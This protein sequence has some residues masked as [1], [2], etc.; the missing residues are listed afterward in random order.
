MSDNEE[1][2]KEPT[3]LESLLASVA[4][5]SRSTRI[6][7]KSSYL[8]LRKILGDDLGNLTEDQIIA[9]ILTKPNPNSQMAIINIA[10]L[11]FNILNK[12]TEK[13]RQLRE[14]NKPK[15]KALVKAKNGSLCVS[16]PSYN[17]LVTHLDGLYESSMWREYIICYLLINIS[18]RNKDLNFEIV[19]RKKDM[20]DTD[21][22]LWY[23]VGKKQ[24]TFVRNDYKT[25]ATYGKKESIITNEFFINAVKKM[26]DAQKHEQTKK[27]I[28]NDG[29]IGYYIQK[30]TLD[31]IGSGAYMKIT[32][33]H[34]RDNLAKI[35][36]M[37][38]NRGTSV[39]TILDSYDIC[40][41]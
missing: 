2:V 3:E 30:S 4:H 40:E 6:N 21:N 25:A 34:Y 23:S 13:M 41:Q 28:P 24:I 9:G 11:V 5:K 7:Y 22:F 19:T 27:F 39:A 36:E 10:V 17:Q 15:L 12:S 29:Q 32:V 38:D 1:E 35:K 8:K 37:S 26:I 33:N 16:L 18:V 14:D 31:Q 20:N